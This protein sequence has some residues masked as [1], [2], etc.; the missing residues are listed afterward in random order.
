MFAPIG[1]IS[2]HKLIYEKLNIR[3]PDIF[4][5]E[6]NERKELYGGDLARVMRSIILFS[7]ADCYESFIIDSIKGRLFIASPSGTVLDFYPPHGVNSDFL[8]ESINPLLYCCEEFNS[9]DAEPFPE[10]LWRP[11][12]VNF[13]AMRQRFIEIIQNEAPLKP[14]EFRSFTESLPTG[15]T[16]IP[17]WYNR[18]G[19]FISSNGARLAQRALPEYLAA[20]LPPIDVLNSFEGWALCV[21]EDFEPDQDLKVH[22]QEGALL[23]KIEGNNRGNG[24][25]AHLRSAI[26]GIYLSNPDIFKNKHSWGDLMRTLE[27]EHGLRA[28]KET[29]KRAIDPIMEQNPN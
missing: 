2:V 18:D 28:S 14:R 11:A 5:R 13:N 25:P 1:Y 16:S 20:S 27:K 9:D 8:F 24:R 4:K 10:G 23:K 26:A 12:Y 21:R 19:Y 29:I 22:I 15:F 17:T 6:I 7:P 3:W